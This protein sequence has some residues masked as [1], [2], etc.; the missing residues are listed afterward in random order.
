M[1]FGWL[2]LIQ[3]LSAPS[4]T[5]GVTQGV[6]GQ[7]M[8]PAEPETALAIGSWQADPAG[9]YD[10]W[11]GTRETPL[12]DTTDSVAEPIISEVEVRARE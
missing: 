8:V 4:I 6:R 10:R 12:A 11:T 9:R 5:H 2:F 3:G 1:I 7:R